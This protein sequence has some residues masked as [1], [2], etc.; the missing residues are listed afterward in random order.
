MIAYCEKTQM[1]A[2]IKFIKTKVIF[3]ESNAKSKGAAWKA[4]VA[5]HSKCQT[6]YWGDYEMALACAET[7]RQVN[8][9]SR[10]S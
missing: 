4:Q 9:L 1:P 10:N 8:I 3:E 5:Y 7:E 6:A 2:L